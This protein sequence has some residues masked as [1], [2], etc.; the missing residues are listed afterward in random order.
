M[1]VGAKGDIEH[2]PSTM[3]LVV[4][5]SIDLLEFIGHCLDIPLRQIPVDQRS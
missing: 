4:A 1:Y 5:L 2:M 3:R